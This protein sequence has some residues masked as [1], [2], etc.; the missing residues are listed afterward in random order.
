[1]T[2]FVSAKLLSP[3][4]NEKKSLKPRASALLKRKS[5][6]SV[7]QLSRESED[8]GLAIFERLKAREFLLMLS[9]KASRP[10]S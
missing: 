2:W 9:A 4:S 3:K 7:A 5:T 8:Q 6:V 1:M 10:R